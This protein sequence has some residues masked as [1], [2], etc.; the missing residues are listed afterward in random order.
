[1]A[2]GLPKKKVA[3]QLAWSF[4]WT[5]FL[6]L[7]FFRFIFLGPLVILFIVIMSG[8]GAPQAD[9]AISSSADRMVGMEHAEVRYFTRYVVVDTLC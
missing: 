6:F 3:A 8:T 7:I 4:I 9:A 2:L 1:M 5:I